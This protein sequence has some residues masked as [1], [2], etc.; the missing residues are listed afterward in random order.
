VADFEDTEV[1]DSQI[2]QEKYYHCYRGL[3]LYC[4]PLP[5]PWL[6]AE[7]CVSLIAAAVVLGHFTALT[8]TF[9][10]CAV[11]N[12]IVIKSMKFE[13]L[14]NWKYICIISLEN[15]CTSR[16]LFLLQFLILWAGKYN[17]FRKAREYALYWHFKSVK[18]GPSVSILWF[19]EYQDYF[20]K[21]NRF[22]SSI[23]TSTR[24]NGNAF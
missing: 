3:H 16:R 13:Q 10:T 14:E 5:S 12:N 9:T 11:A 7:R 23:F 24:E 4:R 19:L 2:Y 15:W 8:A 1:E 6:E 20:W 22:I 17:R 18:Q 21:L